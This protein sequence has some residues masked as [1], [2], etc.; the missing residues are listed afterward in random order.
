MV[1]KEVK[2][3][4]VL[5]GV[6]VVVALGL[7]I[8]YVLNQLLLLLPVLF[9]GGVAAGL[10]CDDSTSVTTNGTIGALLGYVILM[11]FIAIEN[12]IENPTF[13]GATADEA[14]FYI[15]ILSSFLLI[16][17]GMLA[18]IFGYLGATVAEIFSNRNNTDKTGHRYFE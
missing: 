3:S 7:P 9:L 5:S 11:P 18:L 4:P 15:I 17:S 6:A 10:K 13:A 8:V 12:L 2:R 16:F 1:R 14:V